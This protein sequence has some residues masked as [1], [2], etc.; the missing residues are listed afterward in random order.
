MRIS[1][2]HKFIFFAFPKTGS[3]AVRFVLNPL[4][5]VRG[6]T[7][8]DV[9]L[10]D[11]ELILPTHIGPREFAAFSR[12]HGLRFDGYFR[13]MF[14]RNPW[15]RLVSLYRMLRTK[16]PLFPMTFLEWLA[17][18][19]PDGAGGVVLDEP[20]QRWLRYGAYSVD[21]FAG[22]KERRLVDRVYRMEDM[23]LA[24]ADLKQRGIAIPFDHAPTRNTRG[25]VDLNEYYPTSAARDTVASRYAKDIAE[26]RYHY[27]G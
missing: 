3:E 27:P 12:G 10:R 20:D 2:R 8:E 13:F 4:S 18:A 24:I 6:Q 21:A 16:R 5:D 25:P 17:I 9:S 22:P 19:R 1:Q 26:F 7:A 14:V 23:A 15:S 11:G